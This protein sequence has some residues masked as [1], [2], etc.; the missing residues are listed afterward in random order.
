MNLDS[1]TAHTNAPADTS[2]SLPADLKNE[3]D[4]NLIEAC[5]QGDEWAWATLIERYS[6]LIYTIPLRYGFP[7]AIADEIF[8]ETCLIL[9]EGLDTLQNRERLSSWLMTVTKRACIGRLRQ[10]EEVALTEKVD[11]AVSSQ[12][13]TPLDKNLI[14]IEQ[15][16]LV[17]RALEQMPERCQ[18]LLTALFLQEP[19]PSYDE[20]AEKLGISVGSI[21]PNR[22]RCLQKLRL[23]LFQLDQ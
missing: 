10:K 12:I 3:K 4:S 1:P 20:I 5:L 15:R 18:I 9:L 2:M 22:A 16:H 11:T 7:H 8:Q 13:N 17:H 6:R 19:A 21:G 23:I 14:Q